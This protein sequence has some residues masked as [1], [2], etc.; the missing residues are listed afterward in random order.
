MAGKIIAD[1]LETGA[2]AD[3]ATSYVVNGSA[4]A[5]IKFQGDAGTI[6]PSDSLNVG[7]LTDEGTGRYQVNLSNSM[8]S[9]NH[10]V[11]V[12]VAQ[13]LTSIGD[14]ITNFA[15]I[16]TGSFDIGQNTRGGSAVD[17]AT[18]TASTFGDLA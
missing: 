2:G 12:S 10:A 7:S 18:S 13:S 4:K 14:Y 11:H 8:N 6:S 16:A 15:N 9:S 17:S 3:I 1:T 5:W